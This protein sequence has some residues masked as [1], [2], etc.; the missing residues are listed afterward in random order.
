[1]SALVQF[2]RPIKFCLVVACLL[3]V[4]HAQTTGHVAG[5]VRDVQGAV[6]IHGEVSAQNADTGERHTVTTD[7]SGSYVL[8]FLQPGTYQIT[9]SAPG[10]APARFTNVPTGTGETANINAVLRVAGATNE[11]TVNDA[12]P[13]VESSSAEIGLNIDTHTLTS[14]PLPT[15]NF[16]QLVALA[17][18]VSAPLTNNSAIGRNTPNF[19]VNGARTSQNSLRINGI[20]ANDISAHDLTAVAIPAPESIGEFVV[21][22]SMYDASVGGAAGTVQAV[23]KSGSNAVHGSVYEYFR[24][25]TLNANDPNLKAVGL[26][27]PVLRRNVYGATLGGPLRKN[28]AFYFVSYQG[29]REANGATDQSLYK[30]VLIAN[31]LTDDRSAQTLTNTF[32]VQIDPTA[33]ALLNVKLS[34][35]QFLIPTPQQ[36][37][38]VTGTAVSTYREEQFNI[39]LDYHFGL[40]DSLA[41]KFFFADAP[42][43]FALGGATFSGGSSL[44]GFGTKSVVNNR[45]LSLQEVHLF[46]PTTVNEA[47]FGYNFIR[48]NE[49]PQES[50]LDS[51]LGINRPTA[52]SFPGLPLILLA[53][54]SVGAAIGSSSITLRSSSPSLTLVDVLSLQRRQ[55]RIRVGA[56]FHRYVW[57]AVANVNSYGEIDF[58][59]FND[60]LT[61]A[62]DFSSIGTGLDRRDFHASDGYVFAQDDWKVSRNLTVNLG[63]RYELDL[64][65][66]DTEGRIGGFDP[67]LYQPRMEVDADGVPVGP[68]AGG[69]VMAGNA[70]PQYHLPGI[71]LVGKR[72]LKSIDPKNFGPR[73]GLA[74]S[75]LNSDRLVLRGGYGIFYSRPSFIYLGLN[76]FAP[77]F[78]MTSLSLG[79]TFENPFPNA[80]P[81][82]QFPLIEPGISLT[83][84]IMDR[85]NR[86]PYIQQFNAAVEYALRRD[87]VLQVAFVGTHSLRLFRQLP[88]NQ[89][90]IAST[91]HPVVNAVTGESIT[92]N[93]DDNASLRAPFQGVE[94][95]AFTLNQTSGQSNYNS[96][97]ATLNHRMSHGFDFQVSY[98]FS[99]SIDDTSNAGGGAFSDGSIDTGSALDTG[100]VWGN[101]FA[102][103]ANRGVSDFDRTHRLVLNGLWELPNSRFANNSPARALLSHWQLSG[104]V[105]AMSGLPID[106]FDPTAGSLYGQAGGRPN[107]AP[108]AV[109]K[110]A[111]SDIP[112]GY[113]LNPFAFS[114]STVQP[115]QPIPSAHDPT[116]I[117]P[118]G[119]TDFGNVGRNV[120]RGPV[121]SN[122]DVSVGKR[123]LISEA[124]AFLFRAD[125]FNAFNHASR[126]NPIS[127]ISVAGQ[128]DA[129]GRILSPGDFGRI[130]GFDSS[131]RIVQLSLSFSF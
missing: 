124:K 37:G 58:S 66:F 45:I 18:G 85:N 42:Q 29:V 48:N 59:T 5:T 3:S 76:Y 105:V 77:P 91:N 41:A 14:T 117:A 120:L 87:S 82:D 125:F 119:G 100:G 89:A 93:T 44:P 16:L 13:L 83:G 7:E 127:D 71:P 73:V 116:A 1:M 8:T 2:V 12:P 39:N 115:G 31:D 129:S 109:R 126:S 101:Q 38:R 22:T 47:R 53:R 123:F 33:M 111:T 40:K 32:H 130:L 81:P 21:Q 79:Q 52:Q 131:P 6:I 61:G 15:R 86:T 114:L 95:S 104:F 102:G 25:T 28:Q 103:R 24:N 67:S 19:S 17:P 84:S 112:P 27:P 23:T 4:G 54:D 30:D 36:D 60:F 55:H 107:W 57:D 20:D 118:T 46:S 122:V 90:R 98:T 9:F 65:P 72:I 128:I 50:V 35:G 108:G 10:F 121:Q 43:F 113:Y 56:E 34:G 11:V 92:T 49:V 99:K 64:P 97:Q 78:Y 94:T 68:P 80:I 106:I 75:P 26:G 69:I 70:L 88:S 110:T 62:S 51:D 74:W 63:L 96:M